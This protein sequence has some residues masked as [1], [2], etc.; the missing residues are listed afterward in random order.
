MKKIGLIGGVGPESSIEYYRLI[1]SLFQKKLDT[2]DYPEL[3]IHSINMTEMLSYV[4]NNQLDKLINFLVDRIKILELS[5]VDYVAIAS[6]TP[7]IVFDNLVQQTRI[8][9]ISI[10][11]ETCKVI[12]SQGLKRVGLFGTKSTM[13]NGFY[14]KVA[15]NYGIEIIIPNLENREYIHDKYM[16]ELVFNKI[17]SDTKRKLIE[18]IDEMEDNESIEG[19]VLGG[20]ELPFILNQ[21]DLKSIEVL[22]TTKIHVESIVNKM[23]EDD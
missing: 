6:N 9:L 21:S 17:N 18:I 5:G 23:I 13:T 8:E 19:L 12:K 7:H 11:E 22:D 10:V 15:N 3:T 1:I 14:N 2:K 20:T 4:F 16:N